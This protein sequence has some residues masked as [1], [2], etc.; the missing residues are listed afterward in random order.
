[1]IEM[2][3][4]IVFIFAFEALLVGL[5][6]HPKTARWFSILPAIFWMYF[7]PALFA[8][9]NWLHVPPELS[10]FSSRWLMPLALIVLIAPTDLKRLFAMGKTSF[11]T[12]IVVYGTMMIAGFISFLL[13]K[14]WLASDAWKAFAALAATWTGGTVNMLAVKE[15]VGLSESQ[16]S[17]MVITDAFLSYGWM[18]FLMVAFHWRAGL[19]S[20]TGGKVVVSDVKIEELKSPR[21][22]KKD[23]LW[24]SLAILLTTLALNVGIRLPASET[25]PSKAWV[26][27]VASALAI[28]A[29]ANGWHRITCSQFSKNSGMWLLYFVLMTMRAQADVFP[30][31]HD[32]IV[33]GAG[34][35][36]L[37]IHGV[38]MVGYAKLFRVRM[39]VIAI[40]SQ[41]AVGGVVSAPV[42]AA[43][44]DP[45][46]VSVAVLMGIFGNLI[47]TYLGLLLGHL[48]R[49]FLPLALL[50][51]A[52][53]GSRSRICGG[54]D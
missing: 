19:D 53:P 10:A 2:L 43:L 34:F 27:L 13:F 32:L 41:A 18:A 46:L 11:L 54:Q 39:S 31:S 12:L 52:D 6:S 20:W 24:F 4:A 8:Y 40:A 30:S 36:W 25:F 23:V 35:V 45:S 5:S 3:T 17:V 1:M 37:I 49:L 14:A 50:T 15:I 7:L 42:V 38:L 22:S 16:F 28:L 21:F 47:G 33:I 26:L 9:F 51:P 48:V 29:A 44:Y